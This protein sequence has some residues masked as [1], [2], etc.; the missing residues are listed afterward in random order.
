MEKISWTDHVG[1]EEV[2]QRAKEVRNIVHTADG[3]K[4]NRIGHMLRKNCFLKHVSEGKTE[5]MAEIM[6]RQ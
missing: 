4:S 6:G 2:L 1:N 5:G 3:R